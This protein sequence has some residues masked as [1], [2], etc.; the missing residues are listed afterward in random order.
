MANNDATMKE[1]ADVVRE[2]IGVAA[3]ILQPNKQCDRLVAGVL[4]SLNNLEALLR[5]KL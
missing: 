3:L 5:A 2:Q 1:K 4:D